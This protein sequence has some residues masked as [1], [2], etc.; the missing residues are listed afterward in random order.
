[1]SKSS[2]NFRDQ[3]AR[4]LKVRISGVVLLVFL[5]AT[6][7]AWWFLPPPLPN[8]VRLGTGPVDGHYAQFGDALRA[9]VK[10]HG[11]ELELVTTAGSAENIRLLL[12]NE[13]DVGL[14]QSGNM[15]DAQA[16]QLVSI[17]TVFYEPV[18][19]VESADWNSDHMQGGRIAI[20]LPGS[21]S[22]L[23][24]RELL[25]D[26]GVREGVPAGTQFIEIGS[27]QAVEALRAGRV[28]SGIFVTSLELPWVGSLFTDPGLRVKNFSLAEA[29]S[30]HYRY[31][32][33]IVIPAGLINLRDEI[34]PNDI[35]L[36]ATTASLVTR[37]N[38]HS[39]LIPL[40]IESA[41]EQLYQGGLLAGPEQFPSAHG[42]EA[43][44]ADAALHY[45]ERGPSFFYR[46][47]PY[48]YAHAATRFSIILLPFLTLLY[49]L[50]RSVGPT[51]RW[52]NQRRVY[53]W[54]RVL[55][56]LEK[57]I[58]ASGKDV[59]FGR[60][61]KELDKV[62]KEIRTVHVPPRFVATM[63]ALRDYHRLLVERLEKLRNNGS[64]S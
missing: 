3:P 8:I 29:F 16:A 33:P 24:A 7:V 51:Y 52:V 41:R 42:V 34:P 59:N 25:R 23:L 21:G 45:F 18:L 4:T 55:E 60:I 44:L 30:R 47:L 48:R 39:A 54:Y 15:S 9:E 5:L 37:P 6:V 1:M 14:V 40:L 61:Q 28:D 2:P 13:I 53:R 11:L 63:I 32:Q 19:T 22:N 56:R 38:V 57:E 46:W 43:P 17:A 62:D 49:P 58:D 35:E 64:S 26:Q 31:L 12:D 20:G 50:L 36:I 10:E 27:K